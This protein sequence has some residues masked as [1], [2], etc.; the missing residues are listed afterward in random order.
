MSISVGGSE[1]ALDDHDVAFERKAYVDGITYLLKGLPHDLDGTEVRQMRSALPAELAVSEASA[2][3]STNVAAQPV[4]FGQ[5]SLLHRSVQ[6]VVLNLVLLLH[7]LLPYCMLL[8]KQGARLERK[9]KVTEQVVSCGR[10]LVNA[11][12]RHSVSFTES[13]SEFND[14][15]VGQSLLEALAWTVNGVSQGISD[16][17]GQGLLMVGSKGFTDSLVTRADI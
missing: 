13:M 5:R 16:G 2:P 1:P 15:R 10:G 3:R 8:V 11:I 9:Y 4:Q 12:G 6:T 17:V 14:G 7:F